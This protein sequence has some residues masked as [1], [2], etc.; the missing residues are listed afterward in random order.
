MTTWTKIMKNIWKFMSLKIIFALLNLPISRHLRILR[1]CQILRNLRNYH[2]NIILYNNIILTETNNKPKRDRGRPKKYFTDEER[3]QAD[4]RYVKE[5]ME[6][7]PF[8]CVF[9]NHTYHM[10]S[11]SN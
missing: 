3:K 4:K 2:F 9:C 10:A 8:Y 7:N 11:K 6:R 5:C 1:N